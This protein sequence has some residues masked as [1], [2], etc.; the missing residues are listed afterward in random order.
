MTIS[1]RIDREVFQ[2]KHTHPVAQAAFGRLNDRM[3][4]V[5]F[6]DGGKKFVHVAFEGYRSPERQAHLFTVEKTTKARPWQSAHQYGL[7]VDFA[8]LR[9][10]NDMIIPNSWFWA[11]A[12]HKSWGELKRIAAVEGLDIPI[13]W[14]RGHVQHPLWLVVRHALSEHEWNWIA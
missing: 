8:C 11:Q 4:K 13:S 9:V 12:D 10:E 1:K 5:V 14:D 2:I 7:A 6:D 3:R